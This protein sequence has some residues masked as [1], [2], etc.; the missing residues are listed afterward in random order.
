VKLKDKKQWSCTEPPNFFMRPEFSGKFPEF[1]RMGSL[2]L[3]L[4]T[5]NKPKFLLTWCMRARVNSEV[6]QNVAPLTV[7]TFN[8]K[9]LYKVKRQSN[10]LSNSPAFVMF[11]L[12]ISFHILAF[13]PFRI[14]TFFLTSLILC[15][16]S[17]KWTYK[18][19]K[20]DVG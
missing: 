11:H 3:H 14:F 4:S 13:N 5:I 8:N 19:E 9:S 10:C 16:K 2:L 17:L 7:P 1:L 15:S 6:L 20:R 12:F 18:A